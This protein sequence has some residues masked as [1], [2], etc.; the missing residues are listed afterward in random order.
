MGALR[1]VA[2]LIVAAFVWLAI[3]SG[4]SADTTCSFD[5]G[6]KV[7]TVG[8]DP[9][10]GTS[11]KVREGEIE[12]THL[13]AGG[14]GTLNCAG[15]EP[16]TT[17]T[18]TIDVDHSS[19]DSVTTL[20]IQNIEEFA[21]GAFDES[22]PFCPDEIEIRV[23]LGSGTDTLRLVDI[24]GAAQNYEIGEQGVDINP[25]AVELCSDLEVEQV[26]SL[27]YVV[28]ALAKPDVV[29]AQGGLAA[30]G[31]LLFQTLEFDGGAGND[32]ATGS[33]T[34]DELT[35]GP[36]R[37]KLFGMG[38][39]DHLFAEDGEADRKLDCGPGAKLSEFAVIDPR[40]DP[41]PKSC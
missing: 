11:L 29:T 27:K 25:T 12:V 30:G 37:D 8:G 22:G 28:D 18:D 32:I 34:A 41:K 3:P 20:T 31:P 19:P 36:G 7:L 33:D 38:G 21:P 4:A 23:D 10:R 2:V 14:A 24:N 9:E 40:K 1:L 39:L 17:N 16:T 13:R 5:S 6:T 26:K 35:G 15:P